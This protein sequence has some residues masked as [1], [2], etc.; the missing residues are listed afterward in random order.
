MT[1]LRIG[2]IGQFPPPAA[3]PLLAPPSPGSGLHLV[4]KICSSPPYNP[5]TS[6]DSTEGP[7]NILGTRSG[8]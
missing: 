3:L 7:K 2:N 1:A 6:T 8:Q 4:R 5:P